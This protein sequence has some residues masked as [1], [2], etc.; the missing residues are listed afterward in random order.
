MCIFA[1][2]DLLKFMCNPDINTHCASW[3]RKDTREWGRSSPQGHVYP[4]EAKQ[5]KVLPSRFS[6]QAVLPVD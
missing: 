6:R 3:S 5:G 1:S 4:A 2:A